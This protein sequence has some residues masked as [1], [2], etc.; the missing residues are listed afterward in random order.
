MARVTGIG[1]VFL[2]SKDPKALAKWYAD[3]LGCPVSEWG[4]IDFKW[5]DEVPAGTGT[6][7]WNAFPADTKY[8]GG[9]GQSFMLNLRVDDLD[10]L[11]EKLK[12]LGTWIDEKREDHDYGRFA[13]INDPEGNRVELWQPLVHD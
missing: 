9:S 2:R 3:A 6:T 11:L 10:G 1:G 13:W 8:F 12:G 5:S 7:V 4:H